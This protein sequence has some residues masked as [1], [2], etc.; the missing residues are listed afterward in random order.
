M[1]SMNTPGVKALD[2]WDVLNTQILTGGSIG[3]YF[4]DNVGKM[5]VISPSDV[6]LLSSD[7]E[8]SYSGTTT[9]Q[10]R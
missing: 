6:L 2:V 1:P 4:L 9:Y 7:V 3:E 10:R 8:V 5:S